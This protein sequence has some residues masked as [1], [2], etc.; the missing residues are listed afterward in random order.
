MAI[1]AYIVPLKIATETVNIN[2]CEVD[3]LVVITFLAGLQWNVQ[4]CA[5]QLCHI[6]LSVHM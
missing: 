3:S 1:F 2:S 4:K 6:W 5:Y